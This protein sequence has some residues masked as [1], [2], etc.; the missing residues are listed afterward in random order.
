MH[1]SI[2][3]SSLTL[4]LGLLSPFVRSLDVQLFQSPPIFSN[5]L[6]SIGPSDLL[7]FGGELGP[8]DGLDEASRGVL[9]NSSLSHPIRFLFQG[10]NFSLSK[11][12]M[13][14]Y[15]DPSVVDVKSSIAQGIVGHSAHVLN[16]THAL[17]VFG[18]AGTM[19]PSSSLSTVTPLHSLTLVDLTALTFKPLTIVQPR[20]PS[21]RHG[22]LSA[23]SIKASKIFLWGGR[24]SN[25]INSELWSFDLI[26]LAW[27]FFRPLAEDEASKII[28]NGFY[29]AS[30]AFIQDQ[31]W[32]TCFG[33]RP[34]GAPSSGCT[35]FDADNS[36]FSF[37]NIKGDEI[38]QREG[39]SMVALPGT[40]TVIVFGGYDRETNKYLDDLYELQ[41]ADDFKSLSI[42]AAR[43]EN[44][45]R[46][47]ARA[48]HSAIMMD[49]VNMMLW[50]GINATGVRDSAIHIWDTKDNKWMN[51]KVD[52]GLPTP[53]LIS[54][55]VLGAL[56][57]T[58]LGVVAGIMAARVLRTRRQEALNAAAGGRS[59]G[60]ALGKFDTM[61]VGPGDS[62]FR[63]P[64]EDEF[65]GLH[66]SQSI[67]KASVKLE[68]PMISYA[69]VRM[70]SQKPNLGSV[71]LD[72]VNTA[73]TVST[74]QSEITVSDPV[75]S[76]TSPAG[77]R[78]TTPARNNHSVFQFMSNL[79][80]QNSG[81]RVTVE[82]TPVSLDGF[83]PEMAMAG[84]QGEPVLVLNHDED[85]EDDLDN[86]NNNDAKTLVN[87]HQL[88]NQQLQRLSS[89]SLEDP[90][91]SS[92]RWSKH[93]SVYDDYQW[94]G[95]ENAVVTTSGGSDGRSGAD[96]GDDNGVDRERLVVRN[97]E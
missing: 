37:L 40:K 12:D 88:R 30:G 44:I 82:R 49:S 47:G 16:K 91:N 13:W 77:L 8:L 3:T 53:V 21:P 28:K 96:S 34:D 17:V 80:T 66:A 89:T 50:G 33:L 95:F 6:L 74:A 35:L 48:Y 27:T 7:S 63:L 18:G 51:G 59:S 10:R 23:Y 94:V 58:G 72:R 54:F 15:V 2:S 75:S 29:G 68:N 93:T 36:I 25:G 61:V 73:D 38:K 9:T 83:Q 97:N 57:V 26:K 69:A 71:L 19:D 56:F 46:T 90:S 62:S 78:S 41:L 1:F 45:E 20:L 81:H 60:N 79:M 64:I 22:H 92:G 70:N 67:H 86:G 31:Y 39:A 52:S 4:A 65:E 76:R 11:S 87:T 14:R 84:F 55:I 42:R 85:F 43:P 5:V 24:D 32:L